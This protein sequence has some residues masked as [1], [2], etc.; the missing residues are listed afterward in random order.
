ML[1][2]D[3]SET[4]RFFV[5]RALTASGVG[6][7]FY[8]VSHGQEAIDYLKAVGEFADRKTHPFPNILLLDIKMPGLDGFDVLKW[9][10]AHPHCKV[11][12]TIM[13]SSSAEESDVH[14]AYVLGANAYTVK[15]TDADDLRNLIQITYSF[16]SRCQTPPPPP[17]NRC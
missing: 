13:F 11:I 2:A 8:G 12:P 15:P 6:D 4:D 16:W 7:F 17:G 3:D 9:L 5:Q 10:S 14:L 1:M